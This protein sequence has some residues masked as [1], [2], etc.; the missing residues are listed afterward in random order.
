M[1]QPTMARF[2]V[3]R[4][5]AACNFH[6]A[7]HLASDV[8]SYVELHLTKQ[9]WINRKGNIY[10]WNTLCAKKTSSCKTAII[11]V[12]TIEKFRFHKKMSFDVRHPAALETKG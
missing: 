10:T 9:T 5:W 1:N 4:L 8:W 12:V 2:L 7:S 6:L 3:N 11:I